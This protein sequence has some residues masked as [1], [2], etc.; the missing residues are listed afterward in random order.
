MFRINHIANSF[1]NVEFDNSMITCDPWIG[2]TT[3]NAW[4]S[5]PIKSTKELKKNIFDSD[6]IYISHLH[7]D[8]LDFK[9]LKKFKNKKLV[10]IIKKFDNLTLKKR[11]Q[12]ITNK[13]IELEPFKKTKINKDFSVAIIPQIISNSKNLA[14]NINYDLDTSIIIQSNNCKTVFFNNVDTALNMK[15]LKKIKRFVKNEFNKGIDIFCYASGAGSEFPQCFLNLNRKK[16]KRRVVDEILNEVSSYVKFLR[17]SIFFPAGGTYL[18]YGKYHK[19]NEYVAKPS[20]LEIK[21]KISSLKTK[22]YNLIGGGSISFDKKIYEIKEKKFMLKN[23]YE[24]NF[25]NHIKKMKYYYSNN[26][27]KIDLKKLDNIFLNAKINYLKILRQ[28][29]KIKAKWDF[30]F[31]IY[32]NYEINENCLIDSQKSNFLKTY[33]LKHYNLNTKNT[34]YLE[35]YLEYEL[36]KS[37][38]IGKF[39]WNT[40]LSGSTIMFKRNPNIFNVDMVLSLN[41]LRI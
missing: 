11:L 41:F 28:N 33:K 25:L 30:N 39:P 21:K 38:L 12:K 20:F 19:L 29:E 2:K 16:E 26:Y 35:C 7:C 6:F 40:S 24:K 31:K 4:F 9:T 3:S 23:N 10:F 1:I 8:H 17:P 37:L 15:I 36:F 22:V 13:I 32:K 27:S 14:D 5:Y 18:I 34:F